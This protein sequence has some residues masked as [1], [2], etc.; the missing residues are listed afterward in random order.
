MTDYKNHNNESKNLETDDNE[1]PQEC[2]V[3]TEGVLQNGKPISRD[4]AAAYLA[5]Y[6]NGVRTTGR[7][8]P[9][10]GYLFGLEKVRGFLK[11]IDDYNNQKPA[12]TI[13]GVRVYLGRTTTMTD[14]TTPGEQIMNT[15]FLMPVFAN[16]QD[17]Y[18]IEKSP[19]QGEGILGDPR[20]CP[21][22]CK[23]LSFFDQL[24]SEIG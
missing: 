3:L 10:Y 6:L 5:N 15:V 1:L 13:D 8:E 16:G 21:N 12:V 19:F 23:M 9:N 18:V 14:T 4:T 20:P 17:V 24:E 22:Q 11:Q 2:L 7:K